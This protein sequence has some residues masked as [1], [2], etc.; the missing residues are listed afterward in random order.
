MWFKSKLDLIETTQIDFK[1]N[2]HLSTSTYISKRSKLKPQSFHYLVLKQL[3]NKDELQKLKQLRINKEETVLS[4]H[5]IVYI[6][7]ITFSQN[8]MTVN[9]P[10]CHVC[11]ISLQTFVNRHCRWKRA[12]DL[13]RIHL[14]GWI[15]CSFCWSFLCPLFQKL[16]N[17]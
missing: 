13:Q 16:N 11:V 4:L 7:G 5:V 1:M 10:L 12:K 9:F 6:Q 17:S 15:T 3:K 14:W 2:L 8:E